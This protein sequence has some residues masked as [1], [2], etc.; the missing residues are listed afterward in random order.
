M[1]TNE[2][3]GKK[4]SDSQTNIEIVYGNEYPIKCT[5]RAHFCAHYGYDFVRIANKSEV[6]TK[7][8]E[9]KYEREN[10][11]KGSN[12]ANRSQKKKPPELP[13]SQTSYHIDN[14]KWNEMQKQK[15][16]N[17]WTKENKT[18]TQKKK[19]KIKTWKYGKSHGKLDFKMGENEKATM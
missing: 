11:I 19:L 17:E 15:P 16:T 7:W 3:C 9:I 13:V 10:G 1:R 8:N 18:H 14:L 6:K 4:K 5:T 12:G 2:Y